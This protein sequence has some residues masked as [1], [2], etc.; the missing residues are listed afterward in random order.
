MR[1]EADRYENWNF[2]I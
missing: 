1:M 2:W